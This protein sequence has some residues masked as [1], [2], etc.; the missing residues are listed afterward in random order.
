MKIIDVFVDETVNYDKIDRTFVK[1]KGIKV[2]V[3]EVGDLK[4][5]KI[6]A[7]RPVDFADINAL[8]VIEDIRKKKHAKSRFKK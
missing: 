3:V 5:L 1:A 6:K 8:E 7:A 2:P 4:R